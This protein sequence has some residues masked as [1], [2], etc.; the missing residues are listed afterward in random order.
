MD[1]IDDL[2]TQWRIAKEKEEAA[3]QTRI[4]IEAQIIKLHPA[5][6][7]GS[8]TFAT[9]SGAKVTL[10][11]KL[12][13]KVDL[14]KLAALTKGWPTDARPIKHKIEADETKLKAIRA[15]APSLWA[16]IAQAVTVTPAKTGVSIEWK[17]QHA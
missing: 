12:T 1:A 14:E 13:Y 9:P 6:E 4:F 2:A 5:K 17:E 7:Q 3:R 8:E 16:D 11:G 10:T 15:D